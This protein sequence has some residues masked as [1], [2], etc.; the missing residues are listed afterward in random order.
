MHYYGSDETVRK[1]MDIGR[2]VV[3]LDER[4]V[5]YGLRSVVLYRLG[6]YE[7][8]TSEDPGKAAEYFG[9]IMDINMDMKDNGPLTNC[10]LTVAALVLYR[11]KSIGDKE[12]DNVLEMAYQMAKANIVRQE[13]YIYYIMEVFIS[14][15]DIKG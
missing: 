3:S 4:T 13:D 10:R 6:L 15:I 7:L 14:L 8:T 2:S 1:V 9:E 11:G 12:L 5:S